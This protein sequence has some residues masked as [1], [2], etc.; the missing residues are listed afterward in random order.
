MTSACRQ[1]MQ[2]YSERRFF[3]HTCH[4]NLVQQSDD[5]TGL[6]CICL[7]YHSVQIQKVLIVTGVHLSNPTIITT[8]Q[9]LTSIAFIVVANNLGVKKAHKH[10]CIQTHATSRNTSSSKRLVA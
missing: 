9:S 5:K 1:K 7:Q 2:M 4:V 3:R 6:S 8:V 10:A